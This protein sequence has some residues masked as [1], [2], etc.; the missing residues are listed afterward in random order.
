MVFSIP[1][2]YITRPRTKLGLGLKL[3]LSWYQYCA[4][5][6]QRKQAS[7]IPWLP[8]FGSQARDFRS[9]YLG[10]LPTILCELADIRSKFP[11]DG[12]WGAT[13]KSLAANSS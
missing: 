13:T 12:F 8:W 10:V 9:W 7:S 2:P 5:A 3:S 1:S 11:S 6:L 4:F